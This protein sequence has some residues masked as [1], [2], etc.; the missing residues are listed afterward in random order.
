MKVTSGE[1]ER[2]KVDLVEASNG[3]FVAMYSVWDIV[4][5][6]FSIP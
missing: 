1:M 2:G 4:E 5:T 3:F 6:K